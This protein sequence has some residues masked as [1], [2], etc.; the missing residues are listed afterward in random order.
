M[1]NTDEVKTTKR[2]VQIIPAMQP[3]WVVVKAPDT[4]R[5]YRDRVQA[6]ALVETTYTG[7][8]GDTEVD[9]EVRP[10]RLVPDC[11]LLDIQHSDGSFLQMSDG[12]EA[13]MADG[14]PNRFGQD[15]VQESEL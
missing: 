6:W 11:A 12:T 13:L 9:T 2:I 3:A 4:G 5:L 7:P 14:S 1:S 8:E 10:L 15:G